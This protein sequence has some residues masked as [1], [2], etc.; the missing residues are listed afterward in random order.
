[1]LIRDIGYYPSGFTMPDYSG[2]PTTVAPAIVAPPSI[3]GTPQVGQTLTATAAEWKS[4][5][6]V[7]V[8]RRWMYSSDGGTTWTQISGA[9]A[10]TYQV[11]SGQSGQAVRYEERATNSVGASSW[12]ASASTGTIAA[13]GTTLAAPTRTSAPTISGTMRAGETLTLTPG[14]YAGNPTPVSTWRWHS[15]PPPGGS[16]NTITHQTDGLTFVLTS[17]H[18]GRQIRV[19]DMARNSQGATQWFY[20]A[21]TATVEAASS[22]SAPAN[23][24]APAV[25]GDTQAGGTLSTSDGEWSE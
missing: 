20:N 23:L 18:E 1:M 17:A 4:A 2:T 22:N 19:I 6:P 14:V 24:V 13:A 15:S 25:S 16:G 9:T 12:V 3:S 11:A 7:T 8:E 5:T 10:L 21:Y